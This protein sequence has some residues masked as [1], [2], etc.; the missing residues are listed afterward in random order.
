MITI[1]GIAAGTVIFLWIAGERSSDKNSLLSLCAISLV[2]TL[3][4][5]ALGWL[6]DYQGVAPHYASGY[7]SG[8]VTKICQRGW[9]FK[10]WEA[11]IA[12]TAD[13]TGKAEIWRCSMDSPETAQRLIRA[14]GTGERLQLQY[15]RY[16]IKPLRYDSSYILRD[17]QTV[18]P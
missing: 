17:C 13:D 9:L 5:G 16:L 7:R 15:D 14:N 3:S 2:C 6:V 10:S 12:L 11:D 8:Q 4:C 1:L 18:K